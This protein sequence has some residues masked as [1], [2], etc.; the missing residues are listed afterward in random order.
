MFGHTLQKEMKWMQAPVVDHAGSLKE[1]SQYIPKFDRSPFSGNKYLDVINRHPKDEHATP[2]SVGVVSKHYQL[3][4]HTQVYDKALKAIESADIN[5]ADVSAQMSLTEYGERMALIIE[6][7]DSMQIDPGDG[8]KMSLNLCFFNS[9]D[10]SSSFRVLLG[11]FRFVCSNGMVVGSASTDYRKR[12]NHNLH[13]EDVDRLLKDGMHYAEI[14]RNQFKQWIHQSV[15]AEQITQWANGPIATKWGVKAATRAFHIA[16]K[17]CDAKL[18]KFSPKAPPSEKK[19]ELG[20]TVPGSDTPST[21]M[22]AAS[23]VLTWL[24]SQRRD[25]EDQLCWQGDIPDLMRALIK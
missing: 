5:I 6:L 25:I 10:G 17:G 15:T 2:V 7:P 14:E 24:A 4:Q 22:F 21:N 23:Q 12:H 16:T 18:L 20:D 9:V 3:V 8:K 1:M 13:L 11:W 19:I